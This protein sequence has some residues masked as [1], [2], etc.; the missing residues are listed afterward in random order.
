[1]SQRPLGWWRRAGCPAHATGATDRPQLLTTGPGQRTPLSEE[2]YI[3]CEVRTSPLTLGET[4]PAFLSILGGQAG[5]T[6]P[7]THSPVLS[8]ECAVCVR[9][10]PSSPDV[11]EMKS[12]CASQPRNRMS[13]PGASCS[14]LETP[15]V[16]GVSPNHT[17]LDANCAAQ[18]HWAEPQRGTRAHTVRRPGWNRGCFMEEMRRVSPCP[19]DF[20]CFSGSWIFPLKMWL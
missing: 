3:I 15:V 16:E 19:G 18:Q 10:G 20:V 9:P 5:C 2:R 12:M 13:D 11:A 14:A 7:C 8:A 6:S 17:P 1:M 4:R